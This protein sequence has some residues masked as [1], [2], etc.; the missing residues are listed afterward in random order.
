MISGRSERRLSAVLAADVADYSRMMGAD[1]EGT[2]ARL[3]AYRRELFDPAIARCRGRLV[4]TTG[5]GLLAT[6]S[7]VI[8]AVRCAVEVQTRMAER[9][10]GAAEGKRINFRVGINVGDIVEQEGDI[11]GDGVNIAARLESIAEP[12]GI[13]VSARVQEDAAGRLDIGFEDMGEQN[14]KNIARPVRAYRVTVAEVPTLAPIADPRRVEVQKPALA[15]L[16]FLN[17]SGDADQEY[18]SDGV[19]EDIITALS[20][21]KSFAVIARN[22][23]F[24][25]KGRAVDIRQVGR[26][27]GV[28]YVLEGSVRR[29]GGRLR[30]TAQLV[31]AANGA[32]LWAERFDGEVADVFDMQDRI[33]ESLATIVEPQIRSAEIEHARSERPGS[34]AAYGLYLRALPK[35]RSGTRTDNAEAYDLLAKAAALDPNNATFLAWMVECLLRCVV[36]GWV[37]LT[38]DI[39][40]QCADLCHR[41]LAN[42][43]E[44]ATVLALIGNAFIQVPHEFDRGLAT[45]QRAVE[46]N[47]NNLVVLTLAGVANQKCG[48]LDD[49]LTY[50][51]RALRFSPRDT[52][53]F[54]PLTGIAHTQMILGNFGEALESAERSYASNPDYPVT[55]WTLIAANAQLGRLDAAREW[56]VK[57]Q[58]LDP[59]AT[60]ARVRVSQTAKDDTR[61]RAILE[62]LRM[63]GL[64]EG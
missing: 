30:V 20:R 29:A 50:Y 41:A 28:R 57:L 4:K 17:M 43:N 45:I 13:C 59:E 62:G 21:F 64:P 53:T 40:A 15:V 7:S 2:L 46:A 22:S 52:Y 63:A 39:K 35:H 58:A 24:V 31:D 55:Y 11:F 18:F 25:Y 32:H 27:L 5:D 34:M 16:P 47:P 61:M 23:S 37:P 3:T 1:E 6:F 51:G 14:L 42:A 38:E 36:S 10:A 49:A 19:V 8:D 54:V 56:R 33:T 44:D 9:N 12:G 60:V 26:D 48:S